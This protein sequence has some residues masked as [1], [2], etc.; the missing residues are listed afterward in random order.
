MAS[1][2][3]RAHVGLHRP[4]AGR[5]ADGPRCCPEFHGVR[6]AQR[7][8]ETPLM[9]C[10]SQTGSVGFDSSTKR[11]DLGSS[12]HSKRLTDVAKLELNF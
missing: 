6:R 4:V 7:G 11:E 10:W 9:Y 2:T 12:L 3:S 8:F 1:D 5:R